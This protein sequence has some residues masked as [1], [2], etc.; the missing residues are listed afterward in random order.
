[1]IAKGEVALAAG[2]NGHRVVGVPLG[3]GGVGFDVSLVDRPGVVLPLQDHVGFLKPFID[4][5]YSELEAVGDVALLAGRH[6][7]PA[8]SSSE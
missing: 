5:A 8:A 1:M 7:S 3:G 4:V 2:P 6:V